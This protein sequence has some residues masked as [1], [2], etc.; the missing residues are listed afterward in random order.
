VSLAVTARTVCRAWSIRQLPT[1]WC[2]RCGAPYLDE[3]CGVLDIDAALVVLATTG[4]ATAACGKASK[5]RSH[6][7]M[8]MHSNPHKVT[9]HD[10]PQSTVTVKRSENQLP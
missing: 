9:H 5:I 1:S 4:M 6:H 3:S 7:P 2:R 10:G 8:E